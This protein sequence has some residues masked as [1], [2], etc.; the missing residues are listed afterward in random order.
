MKTKK[1]FFIALVIILLLP[2]IGYAVWILRKG[3]PLQVFVVNKS[4]KNF[5]GSENKAFNY[6][7]NT[8]K[9]LAT[10]HRAYNLRTDHYGLYWNNG[11]YRVNFP[12][13]KEL[14]RTAE[15][16]DLFYYA[17]AAGIRTS[18]L[19]KFTEAEEDRLVYGGINNTD[20]NLIKEIV[21]FHKPIVLEC[22][23]FG[24]PTDLLVRYNLEKM[25]DVYYVGWIGKYVRDLEGQA[26]MSS[27]V[28]WKKLYIDYTGNT[29]NFSGKGIVFINLDAQRIV[30]LEEGKDINTL[31]GLIFTGEEGRKEFKL[32]AKVCYEGW[33]MLL[34]PGE[35][36]VISSFDLQATEEGLRKLNEFGVPESFPALIRMDENFYFMSGDF[37][38]CSSSSFLPKVFGIGQIYNKIKSFSHKS[39][40]FFYSY[41]QPFMNRIVK[42]AIEIR[43][44]AQ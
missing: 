17:D 1:R 18:D 36:D 37:G 34:H 15:K 16:Y 29:W 3:T 26:D 39:S 28:D 12:R 5:K 10:G 25:L 30:V 9:I 14:D 32:P 20:Y 38:K 19:Q 8:R 24:P 21:S 33:F 40:N 4:M 42:D 41:Y 13:L 43:D 23:F 11:D 31:K 22:N 35:N 7:L 2:L 27:G 44:L 6:V